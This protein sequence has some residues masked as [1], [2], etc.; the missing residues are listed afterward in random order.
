MKNIAKELQSEIFN[1]TGIK[2]VIHIGDHCDV[3]L[4]SGWRY[5]MD[6]DSFNRILE[7]VKEFQNKYPD[8]IEDNVCA[9]I[10]A[11]DTVGYVVNGKYVNGV[12]YGENSYSI[13]NFKKLQKV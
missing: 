7:I 6:T 3:L 11:P 1:E 9:D 2:S 4:G 13:P 10:T 12:S 8:K 5:N